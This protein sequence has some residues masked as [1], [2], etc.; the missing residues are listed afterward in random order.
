MDHYKAGLNAFFESPIF[1]NGYL[2]TEAVAK[3][4]SS[5]DKGQSGSVTNILAEGGILI[6]S[7]YI[8]PF[9]FY[10]LYFKPRND[11]M[12]NI[13][14]FFIL[15][16]LIFSTIFCTYTF[17]TLFILAGSWFFIIRRDK[18][19]NLCCYTQKSKNAY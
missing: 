2:N 6:S 15:Y 5:D 3:Y 17:Y 9:I 12:K 19:E 11:M 16:G 4:I 14:F 10:I 13:K 7:I 18:N 1:G 8:L